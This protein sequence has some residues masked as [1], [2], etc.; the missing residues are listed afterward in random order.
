MLTGCSPSADSAILCCY[1]LI[2][3]TPTIS[4]DSP[5]APSPAFTANDSSPYISSADPTSFSFDASIA[6]ASAFTRC[7]SFDSGDQEL[8]L[9]LF[10]LHTVDASK[11]YLTVN[12]HSFDLTV[13][14]Q[15]TGGIIA[16][17]SYGSGDISVPGRK[18]TSYEVS[19]R[20]SLKA[21]GGSTRRREHSSLTPWLLTIDCILPVPHHLCR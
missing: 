11:S 5:Y 10:E 21:P 3:R 12:Y 19:C 8:M 7:L 18:V 16:Q 9:L 13:R 2:P 6:F 17:Q 4:F 14:V 1:F 20:P 15:E